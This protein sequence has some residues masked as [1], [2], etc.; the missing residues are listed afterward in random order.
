MN[1]GLLQQIALFGRFAHALPAWLRQAKLE[2]D[3]VHATIRSDL[4]RRGDRLLRIVEDG[5]LPFRASPY[6]RLLRHA[7][8]GAGALSREIEQ[9]GVE[10]ALETLYREGVYVT[11]NEFKGRVPLVRGSLAFDASAHDFDNPLGT[12]HYAV[13]SGGSRSPG[14]RIAIDLAHNARCALYDYLLFE[15]HELL[16][17]R[18][19]VYQPT[20]P[21]SAGVNA[22]LRYSRFGLHPPRWFSQNRSPGLGRS[23]RHGAMTRFLVRGKALPV[24]EHVPLDACGAVAVHLAALAARGTPALVNSNASSGTRVCLA[25]QREGLDIAGTA[26]RLGG[27]PLTDAR[28]RVIAAS[29]CRPLAMYGMGECGRIGLPCGAGRAIDD[30]HVMTDKLAVLRCPVEAPGPPLL[31]NVFTT[32]DP[33]T[34]KLMLNVQSDDYAEWSR[35]DCGCLLGKLGLDLHMHTIRSH[36]KLTSEGLNFLGHDLIRLVEEVLP[37]R[38]GGAPTDYQFVEGEDATGLPKVRLL[39]SPR[40]G[41]VDA[42]RVASAVVTFLNDVSGGGA[43]GERWREGHTLEVVRQEPLATRASK[44]LALHTVKPKQEGAARDRR[45]G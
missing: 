33:S 5:I 17:R 27:E 1:P 11:L 38:F 3:R 30:V 12:V 19:V 25:A 26:F 28:V 42:Q 21:Y 15:T 14:T 37:R 6:A 41:Q 44:V 22:L 31:I 20:L 7:G 23:W 32:L 10:G 34:P 36:E 39:V 35:R 9:E 45:I 2:G 16:G 8:I 18:Y 29:G 43:F 13:E 40:A 4:A 24:P